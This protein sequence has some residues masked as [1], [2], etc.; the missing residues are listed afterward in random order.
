MTP[1]DS[2]DVSYEPANYDPQTGTVEQGHYYL[3]SNPKQLVQY[4]NPPNAVD[5]AL[6]GNG[7]FQLY[8]GDPAAYVP[9]IVGS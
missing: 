3:I 9:V 8:E 4:V 6:A 7:F 1:V 2:S 5:G